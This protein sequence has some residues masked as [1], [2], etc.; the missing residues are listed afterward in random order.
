[1]RDATERKVVNSIVQG[2]AADI[3]KAAMVQ[4]EEW[5]HISS[6]GGGGHSNS[7]T[8]AAAGAALKARACE[9]PTPYPGGR[10]EARGSTG[11][12]RGV[13]AAHTPA[14]QSHHLSSSSSRSS[15]APFP[16]RL[17]AQI[18]DELLVECEDDPLVITQ[19]VNALRTI[20]QGQ[21]VSESQLLVPLIVNVNVGH[22]W[23]RMTP[24]KL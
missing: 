16:A 5:A 4:W 22:S 12:Q 2:S 24:Y 17:V 7:S 10:Q 20:M 11:N 18:H 19:V 23:G 8:T 15:G 14:T 21:K 3:I 6:G 13:Q 9:G 1:V